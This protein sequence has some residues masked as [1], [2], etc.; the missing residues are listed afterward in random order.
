MTK[1]AERHQL[2]LDVFKD[3]SRT[4]ILAG[5][6]RGKELLMKTVIDPSGAATVTFEVGTHVGGLSYLEV[7]TRLLATAVD[8]YNEL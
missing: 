7:K 2:L 1:I 8:K 5:D 3:F 4:E 6:G